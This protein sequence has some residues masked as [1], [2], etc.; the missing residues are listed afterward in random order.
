MDI[1]GLGQ[2][3]NEG[4]SRMIGKAEIAMMK[5]SAFFINTAR[6]ELVDEAGLV[7]ALK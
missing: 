5:K 7:D 6:G 3:L 1:G 2:F 4:S